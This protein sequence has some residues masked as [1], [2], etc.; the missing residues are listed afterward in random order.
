M[1]CYKIKLMLG[2][3]FLLVV[4]A[5]GEVT[6]PLEATSAQIQ[7]C[8]KPDTVPVTTNGDST[9]FVFQKCF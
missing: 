4:A 2:F 1:I 3:C 8:L 6:S 7:I 9:A 5:C